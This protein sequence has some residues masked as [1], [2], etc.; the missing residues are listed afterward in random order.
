LLGDILYE[1]H[2]ASGSIFYNLESKAAE[3]ADRLEH[4][5]PEHAQLL[6]NELSQSNPIWRLAEALTALQGRR[7]TYGH[8]INMID[9]ALLIGRPNGLASK[10]RVTRTAPGQGTRR[11]REIRSLVFT[12]SVLDYLVHRHVLQNS[13][14]GNIR[15]RPLSFKKFLQILERRYGFYIDSAPPGMDISNDLLRLNRTVLEQRLRDL[16]LFV[17]V[18]DAEAMKFLQ[19]RY[20]LAAEDNNEV[21]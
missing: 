9:S 8:L 10:R 12:D 19:P 17:G 5:Y 7:I 18:N 11:T 1:R 15:T 6:D 13:K 16:G 4:D 2:D 20:E 3:L 14:N 21:V